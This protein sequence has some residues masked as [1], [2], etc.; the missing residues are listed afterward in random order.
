MAPPPPE[1]PPPPAAPPSPLKLDNGTASI[2]LGI[3]AQPQYEALGS[4]TD[5]SMSQN[6]F[7]RR[8]RVLVG[9]TLGQ[10]IEYFFE[11]DFANLFKSAAV[12][13]AMGMTSQLKS[14]PGM[15]IQDAYV[16]VKAIGDQLKLDAGYMYPPLAHNAI[17]SAAT[18]LSWDY[19]N[20]TFRHGTAFGASAD[21]AGRDL[22]VQ[23]RGLVAGGHLEYRVGMFQGLRNA[24][25]PAAMDVPGKVGG[26][27]F[28]RVAAR[29]QVNLLDPE[30]GFFYGGT[31]LGLKRILSVGAAYDFQDDYRYWAADAILDHPLGPGSLTAQVNVAQWDGGAFLAL[32]EQTALMSEAGYRFAAVALSPIVRFE[33]RWVPNAT[34]AVPE[35]TRIAAGLAFWPLGHNSN[36]K[37]FYARIQP[38]PGAHDYNQFVIQWQ[39]F[40]Y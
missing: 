7:L 16:T 20:N 29:V 30:T 9:G 25:V 1:A 31:Y 33:R 17:Q 26:R 39:V 36:L 19:F 37:L 10:R 8:V 14:T 4:A 23:L 24:P 27:N 21:P 32:P 15:N 2:R 18:L 3:L 35:E 40:F 11:S 34:A 12:T 13:N 5:D 38:D 22:G 6:L 28:F